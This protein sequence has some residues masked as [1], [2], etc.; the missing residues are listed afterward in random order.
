MTKYKTETTQKSLIDFESQLEKKG[1]PYSKIIQ[2]DKKSQ[3]YHL[4]FEKGY[5]AIQIA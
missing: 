2:E 1:G 3:V 5:T 4:H